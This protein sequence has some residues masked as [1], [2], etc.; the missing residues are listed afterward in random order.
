MKRILIALGLLLLLSGVALADE[1]MW[2]FDAPPT[3]RIKARYGFEPGPQWLEHVRLSSV[4]FNNGGSGSFVSED[5]LVFTN[6]HVGAKCIQ[7][8]S[9]GARDYMKEGFLAHTRAEEAR[10]PELELN[11][12][13]GMEDVTGEV[14]ASVRPDMDAAKAGSARRATMAA[15]EKEC[16]AS[17]RLRC[18]VVTFYSGGM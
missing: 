11:V 4:R 15:I 18:D 10:C 3:A 9:S 5:G 7:E 17:T 16:A 13:V 8:L 12:L 6:H 14:E 1:G 2:L